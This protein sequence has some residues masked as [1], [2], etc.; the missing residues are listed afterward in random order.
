MTAESGLAASHA[1]KTS[2][3]RKK[4]STWIMFDQPFV[5]RHQ[6]FCRMYSTNMPAAANPR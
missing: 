3:V 2:I 1:K 4:R 5:T 6:I